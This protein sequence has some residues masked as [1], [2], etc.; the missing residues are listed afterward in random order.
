MLVYKYANVN[1][2][3]VFYFPVR[4]VG[5]EHTFFFL[6]SPVKKAFHTLC[7]VEKNCGQPCRQLTLNW[8]FP[9]LSCHHSSQ[10]SHTANKAQQVHLWCSAAWTVRDNQSQTSLCGFIPIKLLDK[11]LFPKYSW[12]SLTPAGT[13]T[14]MGVFLPHNYRSIFSF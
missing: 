9:G 8:R 2:S 10:Y 6:F 12:M 4:R 11:P 3:F 13:E 7:S 14:L 5:Q 1:H